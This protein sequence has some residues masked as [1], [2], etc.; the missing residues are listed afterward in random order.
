MR[1]HGERGARLRARRRRP[2][3]REL[4][5][6]PQL[7][8]RRRVHR[9]LRQPTYEDA[10]Q[11]RPSRRGAV[12]RRRVR[13]GRARLHAL[14]LGR[15]PGGR[16]ASADAAR[17]RDPG[18]RRRRPSPGRRRRSARRRTSSSPSPR[19]SSSGCCRATPR[20][21]STPRC[22]NA[23]ASEHAAR[24]RAMKAATD[25]AD[26]LI[27][28]LTAHHEP[29]PPGRDHHRDHGDRRR[30]R[31]APRTARSTPTPST[32]ERFDTPS[33]ELTRSTA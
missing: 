5:P 33:D 27:T 9:L 8:H 22:S 7:P 10:A 20:R 31:G 15:L 6:V 13:P 4:L 2:Q 12:P 21:A 25:N 26:D 28:T 18:G 17:P 11:D 32:N 1:E 19:R 14:R 30:R 29:R 23:A 24:Q 16:R 3:G